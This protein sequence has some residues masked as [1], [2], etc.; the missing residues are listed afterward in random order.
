[1]IDP[2]DSAAISR[3]S[4]EAKVTIAIPTYNRPELLAA[5]I[6]EAR[7]QTHRNLEII[8]ADNASTDPRV[9][10]IC[11][12]AAYADGRVRY[13]RR[14]TN[15]GSM[16]NFE[17]TLVEATGDYFAWFADDDRHPATFVEH[18]LARFLT[19]TRPTALVA[20]ETQYELPDAP[21][22]YFE[23]GFRFYWGIGESPSDRVR[24]VFGQAPDNIIYGLFRRDALFH[25]GR[26]A[27]SWIGSS[28]NEH[29]LFAIAAYNGD[30][31]CLRE[32]G[33]WKR[34][35][36]KVCR[37]AQ[38]EHQGGLQTGGPRLNLV[39][40]VRYH[41]SLYRDIC[42]AYHALGLSL[43]ETATLTASARNR[44][45]VHA[46]QC[47]VGWKPKRPPEPEAPALSRT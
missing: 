12:E 28:L 20:Y 21:F 39:A 44:L 33:F 2:L 4:A 47:A 42:V 6:A 38:W 31:V 3:A 40:L 23:Q 1:M 41:W 11:D 45:L 46:L 7:A 32:I 14:P 30:I 43:N 35:T 8:V 37:N 29:P 13:I 16:K 27:T 10:A 19:A 25:H 17:S 36:K 34:A 18:L 24:T 22:P 26:P 15:I 5:T 9:K